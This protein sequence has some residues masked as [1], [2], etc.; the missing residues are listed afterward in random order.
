MI[1][2][3]RYVRGGQIVRLLVKQLAVMG[4]YYSACF[5]NGSQREILPC[6]SKRFSTFVENTDYAATNVLSVGS[7]TY[8]TLSISLFV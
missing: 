5:D 1:N 6:E 8:L 2:V 4:A 7:A 3:Y